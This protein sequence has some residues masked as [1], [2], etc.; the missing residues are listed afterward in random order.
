M[1]IQITG[2]LSD[3]LVD[4]LAMLSAAYT[5]QQDCIRVW[6]FSD[7]P[8]ELRGLM[9]R[10]GD[11]NWIAVVPATYEARHYVDWLDDGKFGPNVD[12]T[13]L[14]DGSTVYLAYH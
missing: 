10:G 14:A 7:A 4:A 6:K 9:H 3:R 12:S 2:E 11:E 8:Q 13:K 5:T 1:E